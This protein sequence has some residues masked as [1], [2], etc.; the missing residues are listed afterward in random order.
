MSNP[1]KGPWC[2]G[3]R[4][5]SSK[6]KASPPSPPRDDLPPYTS[7]LP[8]ANPIDASIPPSQLGNLAEA[9]PLLPP[10]PYMPSNSLPSEPRSQGS[11]VVHYLKSTDNLQSLSLAYRIPIQILLSHNKLHS[12]NLLHSR[13]KLRIPAAYYQGES[14]SPHP[15]ESEKERERRTKIRKLMSR[16]KISEYN[17]AVLCLEFCEWDLENAIEKW[18]GDEEFERRRPLASGR[19]KGKTPMTRNMNSMRIGRLLS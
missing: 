8:E 15:L 13:T 11:D 6:W 2:Q 19:S 12:E 14:Q 10:P 9:N 3:T 4:L 7:E 5:S 16:C 17:E 18:K 1:H